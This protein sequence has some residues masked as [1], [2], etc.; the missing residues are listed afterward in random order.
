MSVSI[1][2]SMSN[3]YI[4][5]CLIYK[6]LIKIKLSKDCY[7]LMSVMTLSRHYSIKWY[8]ITIS[9]ICYNLFT[10]DTK[11]GCKPE[12]PAVS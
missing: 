4:V 9:W 1:S 2:T 12:K 6:N 8:N 11:A 7:N 10:G 5:L 3:H